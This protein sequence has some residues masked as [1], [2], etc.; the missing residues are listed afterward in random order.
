MR[1]FDKHISALFGSSDAS[2]ALLDNGTSPDLNSGFVALSDPDAS[3]GAAASATDADSFRHN[4]F[5]FPTPTPTPTP[6]TPPVE[7]PSPTAFTIDINWD[8]SVGNAPSA[9]T[10]DILAAVNFLETQFTNPVTITI[11]VG[12]GEIDGQLL[13]DDDLG[14]SEANTVPVSYASLLAAVN[15][16]ANN[17][18]AESVLAELPA[19]SPVN[20]ASY[21]VTTAQAKALGLADPGSDGTD[22]WVGFADASQFT[23]GDTNTSGTVAAGTYDFFATAVH[24]ITEDMGRQMGTTS[25]FGDDLSLMNL[26]DYSAPGT[27]DF[28][29]TTP[30]YFSLDGG[31]TDLGAYN[32]DPSGDW[33]DWGAS[34]TDNSFDAFATPGVLEAVSTNDLTE[35]AALGWDPAGSTGTTPPSTPPSTPPTSSGPTGISF[36]PIPPFLAIGEGCGTLTAEAPLATVTEVGGTAGDKFSY[37][38]SG[39]GASSFS[40]FPTNAGAVLAVGA[41]GVTG[42]TGGAL[43]ALTVTATDETASGNPSASDPVNVV[44]GDN[45]ND[46]INL[47]SLSGIAASAPTFIYGLAGDDTI[48]GAGMTGTLYFDAG[49]GSNTMTGGSG[50]N[51]Y[52]FAAGAGIV[53]PVAARV[54]TA[55]AS[56]NLVPASPAPVATTQDIITNFNVAVDLIDLTWVGW[57]FASIGSLAASATTI[58]PDSIGWQTSGGN[59]YVYA[60]TSFRT[61]ALTAT[62]AKIELLGTVALTSA[63]FG[64]I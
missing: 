31:T 10:S 18:T 38:L 26:L 63:N 41:K 28:S 22:G 47:A 2:S 12:Y 52:E 27:R 46:T 45:G 1:P 43:Y 13:S 6:F 20:G 49:T 33:G 57:R 5:P 7:P 35:V 11:D 44:F 9:F 64:H 8:S 30:G 4:P 14:E 61:E 25:R 59:T 36:A 42:S 56:P 51:V 23:Y 3:V 17:P 16:N 53:S 50:T 54:T 60:N 15:A 37:T 55:S 34:V 21:Y 29:Q 48:N 62:N 39:T 58:A 24:E 19:T 40:L 32:T